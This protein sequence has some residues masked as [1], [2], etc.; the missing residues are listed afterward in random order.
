MKRVGVIACVFLALCS[1]AQAEFLGR[2]LQPCDNVPPASAQLPLTVPVT[3]QKVRGAD[4]FSKCRKQP[5]DL[6]IYGCTFLPTDTRQ[7]LIL[8]NS[9]QTDSEQ[10]CT[11]MYEK[12]HLPPNNWRDD[13]MEAM[14]PDVGTTFKVSAAVLH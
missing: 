10:A 12:A 8:L 3:I 14:T 11:L 6:V 1:N 7:A 2:R 13:A 4:M 5:N 9:D